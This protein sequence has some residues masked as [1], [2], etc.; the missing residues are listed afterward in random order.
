M[1]LKL[2]FKPP[3]NAFNNIYVDKYLQNAF[4]IIF[5]RIKMALVALV[6]QKIENYH[7]TFVSPIELHDKKFSG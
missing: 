3:I 7:K 1:S 6:D 4:K 5:G 2:S